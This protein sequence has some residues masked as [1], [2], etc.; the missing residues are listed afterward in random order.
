[1]AR[2]SLKNVFNLIDKAKAELPIEQSF[3][4]DLKRS[5][6]LTDE[7]NARAGSKTYKPS[8]MNCIRQSYYVITGAESDEANAN[9]VSVGICESGTDRHERIQQAVIDMWHNDI[10]CEYINVANFVRQRGLE[11][12]LDIVK[13]PD[14]S[15]KEYETKLYHKSLNMSFLCDGIIKYMNHYYILEIKTENSN[16]FYQRKDVDPSHYHQ[17]IAYSIAFGIDDVIFIYECRDNCDKK[18]FMYHVTDD[19]KQGL[20]GYIEECDSYIAKMKV[21][22]KPKDVAKKTCSYCHYKGRCNKDG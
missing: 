20:I 19:M 7:K 14:F 13:E 12:Y 21:P 4:N 17:A 2:Q 15:K 10:E 1:M 3:L 16:K 9:Y 22:P 8:G 11:E 6:E 5:I 18:A